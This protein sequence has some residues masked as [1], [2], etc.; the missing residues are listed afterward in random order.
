MCGI[1]GGVGPKA[2]SS[3]N[4]RSQIRAIE[5]RGPDDSGMF[6]ANGVAIGMCRLAIV[7]IENGQQPSTDPNSQVH[8][9]FNG[10]IF[11]FKSL[12]TELSNRVEPRLLKSEADIIIQGYLLFGIDFVS[13]LQ[14]M[15]AI[16]IYDERNRDFFLVRDRLGKKPLW[17]SH[18]PDGTLFFAS[19]VKALLLGNKNLTFRREIVLDVLQFGYINSPNSTFE[20]I[21]SLTPATIL[22]WTE[23]EVFLSK[24]W[25]PDLAEKTKISYRDALEQT[26]LMIEQSVKD[27]LVSERALGAFLSGGYDS[28]IVTSYMTKLT[29][30]R[31]HTFS[32]G[33]RAPEYNEA[34]YAQRISQF[35]D[36]NHHVEIIEPDPVTIVE[37][38][39]RIMDQPFADSS[40]VPTYLLAKFAKDFI[41]VAL[42]GDGGDEIFGGYDRYL[43]A[44]TLQAV[45]PVIGLL[46]SQMS[47]IDHFGFV[48]QR[49]LRRIKGQLQKFP[50]LGE[51]YRSIMSM[52]Q[53]DDIDRIV[54]EDIRKKIGSTE[55]IESFES[56]ESL[57]KLGKMTYSDLTHYLPGDI[58]VKIDMSSMANGIELRSPLLDDSLVSWGL[59]LPD[60]FKIKGMQTKHILKDIARSLV[61]AELIDRP[62]MGFAIPRNEWL[63]TGL[64]E[65]LYDNLTDQTATQRGWFKPTAVKAILNEHM[66]GQ[67]RDNI[68]WPMLMLELWA[69]NWLD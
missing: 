46:H 29:Q 63:R 11:N 9:V 13:K 39:A 15:F 61:P 7:E 49:K 23:G 31:I 25:Y 47:I 42:T 67:D 28:T 68:L 66:E 59:A 58:L 36:T 4:L 16:A 20:E 14:G 10:E 32:I 45:N 21:K 24:Y 57:S 69:R 6:V 52:S 1:C 18:L 37:G 51:R 8:L 19:E 65:M 53:N 30:E 33:F 17:Y 48:N 38:I 22:R 55:F 27:R 12:R 40:I 54:S 43:A 34:S 26:K 62:K 60:K 44:P 3:E 64:R 2:P 5:H 41:V 50:N 35:L 56:I